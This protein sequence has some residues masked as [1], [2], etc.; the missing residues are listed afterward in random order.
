[1]QIKPTL[2]RLVRL[3]FGLSRYFWTR[4]ITETFRWVHW[5]QRKS[6]RKSKSKS[7]VTQCFLMDSFNS[8]PQWR[9][10]ALCAVRVSVVAVLEFVDVAPHAATLFCYDD[11]SQLPNVCELRRPSCLGLPGQLALPP[12]STKSSD[13]S[14]FN[15]TDV[16]LQ[17]I[18]N[19]QRKI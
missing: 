8:A 3:S 15:H 11:S 6:Q 10:N 16:F 4:R 2:A 14:Q 18:G 1:M 7:E 9:N 13:P 17:Y 12:W 5:T 19:K